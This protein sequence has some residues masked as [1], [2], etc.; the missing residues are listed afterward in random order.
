MEE[1]NNNTCTV[2]NVL[3]ET[4]E[5][6]DT[7]LKKYFDSKLFLGTKNPN[8]KDYFAEDLLHT[9]ENTLIAN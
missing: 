8:A 2:E 1:K 5:I 3:G 9:L 6:T 7:P 4:V